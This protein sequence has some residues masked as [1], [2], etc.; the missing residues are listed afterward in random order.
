MDKFHSNDV[1]SG[2]AHNNLID[3]LGGTG[4]IGTAAWL[5]WCAVVLVITLRAARKNA[6][7]A[8]GLLCAWIVFH[9][10]GLTQVNFWDAKVEHQMAWM[11][12]WTLSWL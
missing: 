12:A 2:H 4:A 8:R 3:M 5:F 9:I 11:L 7:F 10:N 6:G 1:F